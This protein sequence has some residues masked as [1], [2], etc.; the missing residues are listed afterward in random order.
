MKPY[1]F[2][3]AT[4][5]IGLATA[6]QSAPVEPATSAIHVADTDTGE[7]QFFPPV[8]ETVA[9][10]VRFGAMTGASPEQRQY[11]TDRVNLETSGRGLTAPS[12]S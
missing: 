9:R 11:F 8:T 1:I 2:V 4:A 5:A 7:G 10:S 3:A 12:L 6:C